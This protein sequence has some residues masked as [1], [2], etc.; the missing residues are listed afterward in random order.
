MKTEGACDGRTLRLLSYNIQVGIASR[1]FHDYLINGWK[2][3]LP[4]P[5]RI[6][7]LQRIAELISGYDIVGLQE[8]DAGSLRSHYLNQTEYLADRAGMPYWNTRVNRAMGYLGQHALGLVARCAP[9]RLDS[10][11]LPSRIPGRGAMV[12][13]FMVDNRPLRVVISHLS[14]SAKAR[15]QQMEVIARL[16]EDAPY[17]VVMADFNCTPDSREIRRLCD[18]GRLCLPDQ[19]PATYPSWRPRRAI[20][21]VL[22]TG[23]LSFRRVECLP[24]GFSD[25]APLSVEIAFEEPP[26][27][28]VP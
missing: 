12:A 2:H 14:L 5:D 6:V 11:P 18:M 9:E 22:I 4:S 3:L 27:F 28:T 8:T 13:D 19:P 24:V 1:N 21:H 20:D 26:A 10:V 7:N 17:G 23:G 25:H 15:H 16:L